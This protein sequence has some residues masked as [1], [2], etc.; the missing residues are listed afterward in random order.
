MGFEAIRV[1]NFANNYRDTASY[2]ERSV[3]S[4]TTY[5]TVFGYDIATRDR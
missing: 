3:S 4:S 2:P 5:D 1:L